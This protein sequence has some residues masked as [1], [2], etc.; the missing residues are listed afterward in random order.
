MT[1]LTLVVGQR[2]SVLVAGA[3]LIVACGSNAAAPLTAADAGATP[4]SPDALAATA[5]ADAAAPAPELPPGVD[6]AKAIDLPAQ[7]PDAA[8]DG[9]K[10]SVK[11]AGYG[12]DAAGYWP[13]AAS[14]PGGG[15]PAPWQDKDIGMV[16]RPGDTTATAAAFTVVAGG[17]DIGGTADSFHFVHQR[18]VGDGEIIARVSALYGAEPASKAGVMFRASLDP[19]AAAVML[20]VVGDPTTGGRLQVRT[21]TGLATTV[22]PPDPGVKTGQFLRLVRTGRTFTAYRSANRA[23]WTRVGS[24][25]AELPAAA[26]V[27][28]ATEAHVTAATVQ[29]VYSYATVD[30]LSADPTSAAW[31]PLDVGTVGGSSSYAAG[32]LTLTAFGEPFTPAQDYFGSVVQAVSGGYRLTARVSAQSSHEPEARAGLM[33]REGLV[34]TASRMSAQASI[35]VSPDK[36]VQFSSRNAQGA[37]TVAGARKMEAK[38]PLWLRLEKLELGAQ[39]Q[40]TGWY[41]LDGTTWTMLDS[42]SFTAAQ[43]LLMGIVAGAG[44]TRVA[45][46]VKLDGISAT[47]LAGDGGIGDATTADAGTS[48]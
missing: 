41:S 26:Y 27:G 38:P 9:G 44:N 33:F 12:R 17:G 15:T 4:G 35:T 7:A 25:E 2:W 48:D 23:T 45:N 32:T 19:D 21:S 11:D 24:A 22:M 39:D 8:S 5:A 18:L 14:L 40:F 31:E 20:A 3:L 36:G 34:S 13:D 28:L 43:P 29:A 16:A 42:V 10:T 46:E 30:N 47:V 37:M 1:R 6:A